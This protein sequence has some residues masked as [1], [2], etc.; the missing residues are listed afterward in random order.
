[1][2][3]E[4]EEVFE[5]N[6]IEY[7]RRDIEGGDSDTRRRA[8]ADLVKALTDAF[9]AEV[10]AMFTGYVTALLQVCWWWWWWWWWWCTAWAGWHE[11]MNTLQNHLSRAPL[12]WFSQHETD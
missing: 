2:R 11:L 12:L 6:P 9:E 8:A 7:I 3:D 10:T 1:V 4:D 5:M